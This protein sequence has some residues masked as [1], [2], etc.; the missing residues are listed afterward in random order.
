MRLLCNKPELWKISVV[1]A[2]DGVRGEGGDERVYDHKSCILGDGKHD[3]GYG[4]GC[5]R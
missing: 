2:H 3:R 4:N 1:A 5:S